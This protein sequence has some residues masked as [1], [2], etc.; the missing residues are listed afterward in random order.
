MTQ[1]P[2]EQP[3][4]RPSAEETASGMQD[5]SQPADSA[6][7]ATGE[8]KDPRDDAALSQ[9]SVAGAIGMANDSASTTQLDFT[10]IVP[11][12]ECALLRYVGQL[13]RPSDPDVED[14]VQDAFLRLHR[15]VG[16]RGHDSVRNIQ[17]WLYK[18]AH[19]LT[20][21]T[22]RKRKVRKDGQQRIVQDAVESGSVDGLQPPPTREYDPSSTSGGVDALGQ[23]EHREACQHALAE[24]QQLPEHQKEAVLLKM[25]Q[26][27]TIRQISEITGVSIGN[28]GY[29]INQGLAELSRRLK[30]AGVI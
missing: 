3:I 8:R 25:I 12:Y 30:T 16:E 18:V 23:L 14:I 27:L 24:L 11:R 29:R 28:V 9:P 4:R 22:L 1:P 21:D 26:G 2:S 19:N 5:E 10:E 6:N 15:Y 13:L 17:T 20:M 7:A